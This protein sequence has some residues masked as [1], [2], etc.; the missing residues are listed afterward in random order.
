LAT[1]TEAMRCAEAYVKAM[2]NT[3]RPEDRWRLAAMFETLRQPYVRREIRLLEAV[4][5]DRKTRTA[6]KVAAV[7]SRGTNVIPSG[8]GSRRT[9]GA[10][11]S[12]ITK[13]AATSPETDGLL[14][15]G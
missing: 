3:Y 12:G 13:N 9:S 11:G 15:M 6:R 5:A 8:L 10:S 2:P 1:G 14:F 7:G 4:L